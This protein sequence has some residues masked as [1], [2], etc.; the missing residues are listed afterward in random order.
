[1]PAIPAS[2]RHV[3]TDPPP[4]ATLPVSVVTRLRTAAIAFRDLLRKLTQSQ[5]EEP[6]SPEE[7]LRSPGLEQRPADRP[8]WSWRRLATSAFVVVVVLYAAATTARMYVRKY[9]I[10]LPDYVRW[11]LSTSTPVVSPTHVFFLFVDHFEPSHDSER[12]R[13]WSSR[14]RSLASHHQD[15]D[16]RPPQHTWLYPGEQSDANIMATLRGLVHDGLGEVGLHYHHGWDSEATLRVR[17][18]TAIAEFQEYGFL[19][20]I[21]G[22]THF[23][24]VH[25]NSGL[26]NSNGIELC[27]VNTELRLL[28]SLGAFADFTFPSIYMDAQPPVVNA[29]YAARDDDRPKSYARRYPLSALSD[30]SADLMIFEGP[31]LFAPSWNIRHLFLDLDDG[32]IHPTIP[33]SPARLDRWIRAAVHVPERP[34]WI[35]IKVFAH[36]ASSDAD[37]DAVVGPTFDAALT[38]LEQ[39][40]N[41]GHKYVLHYVTAREA[42]NLAH[43]AATHALGNPQQYFDAPILPY[44]A[45]GVPVKDRTGEIVPISLRKRSSGRSR[46]RTSTTIA[47]AAAPWITAAP[48]VA[49]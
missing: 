9:Y 21:D 47:P 12:V 7:T 10:F 8:Q 17:F 30:G 5:G 23:A 2:A 24:F 14:Y 35:F 28:R 44:E 39:R 36:G 49:H 4:S 27:G 41:D 1:M 34:D 29:I 48:S 16:G 43:A 33:A 20:T 18:Q 25:G 19:R 3:A 11:S 46:E 38:D 40:Y 15:S 45:D 26:D 13:R 6:H 31:L 32:N 37:E 42:Y 22:Q